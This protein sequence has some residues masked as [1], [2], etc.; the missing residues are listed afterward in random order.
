MAS[1][2][3]YTVNI[4]SYR[5]CV[6]YIGVSVSRVGP[7]RTAYSIFIIYFATFFLLSDRPVRGLA[8]HKSVVSPVYMTGKISRIIHTKSGNYVAALETFTLYSTRPKLPR[9]AQ[10]LFGFASEVWPWRKATNA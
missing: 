2:N 3:C 1:T 6:S 7:T 10:S 8:W 9:Y 5:F 4:H